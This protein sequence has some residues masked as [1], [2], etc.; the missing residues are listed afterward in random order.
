MANKVDISEVIKFSNDFSTASESLQTQLKEVENNIEK[1]TSMED[2]SGTA[3]SN[4]KKYF[5]ELHLTLLKSFEHVLTE[6]EERL[7]NH[8]TV[9][10]S[11][12]DS[13][14]SAI[15]NSGYLENTVTDIDDTHESFIDEQELVRQTLADVSDISSANHP[16]TLTFD[17]TYDKVNKVITKLEENFETYIGR[18]IE[19]SS[20]IDELHQ[21]IE[22]TIKDS[23]EVTDDNEFIYFMG[24]VTPDSLLDLKGYTQEKDHEK[25]IEEAREERDKA[26]TDM[27][28]DSQQIASQAYEHF[29]DG[30]IDEDAY[31][32]YL[33]D[34][35]K[36]NDENRG[37]E[38]I[39]QGFI[40]YVVENMGKVSNIFESNV[41]AGVIS[42]QT[43]HMAQREKLRAQEIRELTGNQPGSGSFAEKQREKILKNGRHVARGLTAVNI[44]YGTY[45]DYMNTDKTLGQAGTKNIVD[46]AV[47][48]LA[49]YGAATAVTAIVG[50][51]TPVGWAVIGGVVVGTVTSVTFNYLY[52]NVEWVEN[53]I[54]W[55]GE[56]IDQAAAWTRDK[57]DR[58]GEAVNGFLSD[59][60]SLFSW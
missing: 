60:E 21:Q 49:S 26:I 30:T 46:A 17:S 3:A 5:G 50:S 39:S 56:K 20:S 31:Y 8:L 53:S 24:S 32:E 11:T 28:E 35:K 13:S 14:E 36:L 6:L 57:I 27:D 9:F 33:E 51:A 40:D 59:V 7:K 37:D 2:F 43:E 16:S 58:A 48:G 45:D 10:E 25:M 15:V 52:E 44:F 18:D 23:G 1:L 41:L 12:V 4:A 29:K 34:L 19:D 47:T 38:E 42:Y 54:D 22:T 55:A